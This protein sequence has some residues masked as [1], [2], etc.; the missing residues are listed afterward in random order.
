MNIY[1][2]FNSGKSFDEFVNQDTS[3]YKDNTLQILDNIHFNPELIERVKNIDKPINILVCAEIWCPD[4]MINVPVVE[5]M[6]QYNENIKIAIVSREGNEIFIGKENKNVRIPTFIVMDDEYEE[7]G[8]FI[9]YPKTV[10]NAIKSANQPNIIVTRRK[11]KKGEYTK[12][13]LEDVLKI[14]D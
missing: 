8:R 5:K 11:Y 12:D 14:I 13:T 2:L 6:R 1:D 7:L 3:V 4:C 10:Y 9:E